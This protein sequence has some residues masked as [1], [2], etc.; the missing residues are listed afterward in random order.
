MGFREVF[1]EHLSAESCHE[2]EVQVACEV[3]LEGLR[4]FQ[5]AGTDKGDQEQNI[6]LGRM[7]SINTI[8]KHLNFLVV[9]TSTIY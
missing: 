6:A 4:D 8:Q 3:G 9:S 7:T 1:S 2:G 5:Q